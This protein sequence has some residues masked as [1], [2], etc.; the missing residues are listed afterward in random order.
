[1][2]RR[3]ASFLALLVLMLWVPTGVFGIDHEASFRGDGCPVSS[4]DVRHDAAGCSGDHEVQGPHDHHVGLLNSEW[5]GIALPA[6]FSVSLHLD[7]PCVVLFPSVPDSGLSTPAP[8]LR[9]GSVPLR[10]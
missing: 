7:R 6:C 9:R 1:M 8:A 10:V 5:D 4:A 3:L 2:T